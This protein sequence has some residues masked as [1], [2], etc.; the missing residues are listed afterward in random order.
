MNSQ[1]RGKEKRNVAD[2]FLVKHNHNENSAKKIYL[3]YT[4]FFHSV[5]FESYE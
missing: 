2:I 4:F 5:P 1:R 3:F